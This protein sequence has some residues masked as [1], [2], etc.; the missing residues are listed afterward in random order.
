MYNE[1][2]K[3]KI[4]A[5][6]AAYY[7]EHKEEIKASKKVYNDAHREEI[8]AKKREQYKLKKQHNENI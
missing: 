6:S 2:N 7:E 1:A 3:E 8:L 4:K 5:R